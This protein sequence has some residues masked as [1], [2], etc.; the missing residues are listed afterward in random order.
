MRV[1]VDTN[2]LVHAR[3]SSQH[4]KQPIAARWIEHLW[5]TRAGRTS[6]QVL[7]EYYVTVTRELSPGRPRADA[8]DDVRDLEAWGPL[9]VDGALIAAGWAVEDRYGF[10]WWDSLVVA[11]AQRLECSHL[12]TEDL[13][14]GQDLGGVTVIDPFRHDPDD[15][16]IGPVH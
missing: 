5:A 11:A 9:V 12:L 6:T 10:S 3:D 15:V 14:D 7:S 8:R 16:L 4:D 13:Q 2:V 1:F